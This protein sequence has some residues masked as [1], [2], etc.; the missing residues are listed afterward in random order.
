MD[1]C[2]KDGMEAE[3][4]RSWIAPD[5]TSFGTSVGTQ[6]PYTIGYFVPENM[7]E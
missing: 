2:R 3:I 7:Y 1:G 6:L 5:E 4:N